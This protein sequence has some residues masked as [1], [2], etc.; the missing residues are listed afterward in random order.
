MN[1]LDAYVWSALFPF[2]TTDDLVKLARCGDTSL[3][4]KIRPWMT[5][6]SLNPE[7]RFHQASIDISTYLRALALLTC[8]GIM[9]DLRIGLSKAFPRNGVPIGWQ[10]ICPNLEELHIATDLENIVNT[11]LFETHLPKLLVL[12]F[13]HM[14][15]LSQALKLPSTL[16]KFSVGGMA[17]PA[18]EFFPILPATLRELHVAPSFAVFDGD[19]LEPLR[20]L[21]LE[22]LAVS[23]SFFSQLSKWTFLPSTL[24]ALELSL[25]LS[26]PIAVTWPETKDTFAS[27]CPNLTDL[28]TDALPALLCTIN[29]SDSMETNCGLP[30]SLRRL[31]LLGLRWH[32]EPLQRLVHCIGPQLEDFQHEIVDLSLID[33]L[34]NVEELAIRRILKLSD[35]FVF[36]SSLT[37]LSCGV[38]TTPNIELLPRTLTDL[39]C[40]VK[41][42]HTGLSDISKLPNLRSFD[43]ILPY[44][45]QGLL[46]GLPSTLVHLEILF[47]HGIAQRSPQN[48]SSFKQLETLVLACPADDEPLFMSPEHLPPR[49][50]HLDLTGSSAVRQLLEDRTFAT[51]ALFLHSLCIRQGPGQCKFI[52]DLLLNLPINL[53]QLEVPHVEGEFFGVRHIRALPRSLRRLSTR[54]LTVWEDNSAACLQYLPPYLKQLEIAGNRPNDYFDFLPPSLRATID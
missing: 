6:I 52:A 21:P 8:N 31:K 3:H 48:L 45:P 11:L 53:R 13:K 35:D 2:L 28:A 22:S 43:L 1:A 29:Q 54:I 41:F 46:L 25:T 9:K 23:F 27:L 32:V 44:L 19:V 30:R 16:T 51:S 37:K 14:T 38:L 5:K 34:P 10:E 7:R 49:I 47:S 15:V 50:T 17:F 40:F 12:D 24:K 18:A 36:P 26:S 33:D 39:K 42:D 20:S 4:A